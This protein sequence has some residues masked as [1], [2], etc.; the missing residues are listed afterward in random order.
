MT[1]AA[2]WRPNFT[3]LCNGLTEAMGWRKLVA[4]DSSFYTEG[5]WHPTRTLEYPWT[6]AF[7]P[8]KGRVLDIG[9]NPQFGL[10]LVGQ[11]ADVVLHHTSYDVDVLGLMYCWSRGWHSIEPAI[12]RSPARCR[13]VV[14]F[15]ED[16]PFP[17]GA[18]D[19]IYCVSTLEHVPPDSVRRWLEQM[20]LLLAPGGRIAFTVDYLADYALGEG[21]M[22]HAW[23]HD[24]APW[25]EK[26]GLHLVAGRSSEIPWHRD[27]D[28]KGL[29]GDEDVIVLNWE[30]TGRLAVYGFAVSKPDAAHR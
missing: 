7:T 15:L 25:L 18:F 8:P 6:L 29:A 19:T 23:N 3:R 24:F 16:L 17:E 4:H 13:I 26:S 9:T 27:Y 10:S 21:N 22:P 11:G 30:G 2:W 28:P 5:F 1:Q 14:G 12:K 20:A